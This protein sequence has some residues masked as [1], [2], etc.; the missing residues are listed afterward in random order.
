MTK[1]EELKGKLSE[2]FELDKADLDFGIH[3][4]IKSKHEQITDYLNRRLPERVNEVLSELAEAEAGDSLYELKREVTSKLGQDAINEDG[5]LNDL[6]THTPLG[7]RYIESAES[8]NAARG[9]EQTETEVYSHLYEFFSRYYEEGDFISRRRRT[10][11]RET[12]AIPY[13]G[14]EVV[15]HW[16]NKD[17]YYI[18]SSEEMKNYTFTI[19]DS[20]GNRLRVQFKLTSMDAVQNDNKSSR[21][22]KVDEDVEIEVSDNSLV[23]PFSFSEGKKRPQKRSEKTPE[24]VLT[25]TEWEQS[26]IDLL[27]SE[28]QTRF[29]AQDTG[30]TGKGDRSI[31]QKHLRNYTRKNTSDYFIHKDLGGFLHRELDFYIKNEVMYLDDI[32]DQSAD[33]L[34]SELRKIKAIRTVAKDLIDFL[35]QFE[36]FQKKLWLKK[37]FVTETNWCIT[38][39]RIPEALLPEIAVNDAQRQEW[40]S[41]YAIDEIKDTEGDLV[42]SG[43]PGYKE[44]LTVEFLKANDRLMLDTSLFSL[45]FKHR[46]LASIPDIDEQTDGLLI[47]S[48]NFQALKLLQ[49]RYYENIQGI[50]IDPPY[51]T[52]D[53]G[54]YYKDSYMSSSWLSAVTERLESGISL[55][56]NDAVCMISTGDEEQEYLA[57]FCRG[58]YHKD[59]FFATLIWEKKKKGSFLSG[60]IAKMKD[61][62]LCVCKDS[63]V[64]HG[65]VGEIAKDT[66]TYPCVNASNSRD[67]RTIPY[68]IAS[69]YREANFSLSKGST[70]SAGNM[71]LVLVSDLVIEDRKLAQEL[72]IEGNWRYSQKIMEEYA[73]QGELY[74]TQ[75]LYLRR[76]VT[77]PREKRLKDIL[78]RVGTGSEEDV[79]LFDL[80]NLYRYGWGSNEDAN[81]E[82]HQIL[83]QQYAASYPKPSKLITLLLASTKMNYGFW[84][85]Y[86]AGSGTTGHAVINLNREDGG[87]RKYILVEMGDYFDTVLKPRIQKVVYSADWKDGKPTARESGV[88][89]CFKYIRLES[90]EDTLNNLELEDKTADLLGVPQEFADDYLLRYSLDVESR[91]SLLNLKRFEDSFNCMLKVYN[92]ETG[93]A[94]PTIIDLPETFNYL[95]GLRVRTIQMMDG[96]LVIEGENPAAESVLVIWRN[97]HE[98]DNAAL[99]AFVNGTLGIDPADTEYSAIYINGDTTLND[100]HKKILLTEQVFH[101]LMFDVQK[102]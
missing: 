99:E 30:F 10:A 42:S 16:T 19:P 89:H 62:V 73:A 98:K 21:I 84:L 53:D 63:S 48:E 101:G 95:L 9:I 88:S 50:Y 24:D 35:A 28:W 56:R 90:Y 14:E 32:D 85:D 76:I 68:G 37:K 60:N 55:L 13:D 17:Q 82:L 92:R 46:L 4:I 80:N 41:L 23:I 36:N 69:K 34:E 67:I 77:E 20:A 64:F 33:Y 71:N 1:F 38:L 25:V 91:E 43:I 26:I 5:S 93:E 44:L 3:R 79:H 45:D 11:G 39:D 59:R 75:D 6:Y 94:E 8:A 66:E 29:T 74:L 2:L 65:L 51:N 52:G 61:Y 83:G 7:T 15:L 27:P 78:L 86:F 96:F 31:F 81:E 58:Q 72:V 49:D 54:F 18:K 87:N 70:I 40:V 100:P 22:F 12:Y 47:H 97:V 57:A 102:L